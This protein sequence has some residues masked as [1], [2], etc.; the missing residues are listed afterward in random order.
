MSL[1]SK[2][3]KTNKRRRRTLAAIWISV[4][5][6]ILVSVAVFGISL[7]AEDAPSVTITFSDG[8]YRYSVK[9]AFSDPG[10]F[11]DFSVGSSLT[12]SGSIIVPGPDFATLTNG[13][14]AFS[15]ADTVDPETFYFGEPVNGNRWAY[16][17]TGWQVEST[18]SL[19]PAQTVF[20]PGD[21]RSEER[22]V[23]KEC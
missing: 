3:K 13:R 23:G 20:Q 21:L 22:R 14:H 9:D 10:L 19:I 7:S 4:F 15:A 5:A 8:G 6:V 12:E 18:D 1:I 17:F 16:S 2:G 11:E